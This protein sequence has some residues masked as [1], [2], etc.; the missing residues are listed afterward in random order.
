MKKVLSFP[1]VVGKSAENREVHRIPFYLQELVAQFHSYYS[2]HR[3]VSED[4]PLTQARLLL[5][6]SVRSVIANGLQIMGVSAPEK[7]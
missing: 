3:V 4:V 2:V 1:E 6:L 7:M 5:L